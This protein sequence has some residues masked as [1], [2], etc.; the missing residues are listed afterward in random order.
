MPTK[1]IKKIKPKFD[2]DAVL[3]AKTDM[4]LVSKKK[5]PFGKWVLVMDEY[6]NRA[7]VRTWGF[8]YEKISKIMGATRKNTLSWM[9]RKWRLLT[10]EEKSVLGVTKHTA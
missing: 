3:F 5:V 1:K 9:P 6:G 10:E 7:I 8:S 2:R 4:I